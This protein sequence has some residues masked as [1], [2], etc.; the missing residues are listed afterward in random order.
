MI[1]PILQF[2]LAKGT[3]DAAIKK[4][5]LLSQVHNIQEI[6]KI[7]SE[8]KRL[9]LE[10]KLSLTTAEA[11]SNILPQAIE[12]YNAL[13]S[14]NIDLIWSGHSQYPERLKNVLGDDAPP[15]LFVKGNKNLLKNVGVGFCGARSSSA[16]GLSI[17]AKCSEMLV[18][19]GF[20]VVSGYA[21]GVDI[22]A[23]SAALKS[24]GMTT[25]VLAEGILRF[26]EKEEVKGL[27]NDNNHIIVSQFPPNLTWIAR[28]A[29][30]RNHL[31]IAL[32]DAMILIEA[33]ASGGTFAAGEATLK[34]NQP[35]FVVDYASPPESASGNELLIKRGGLLLKQTR[36]FE[37]NL[38]KVI[39]KAKEQ[40][41]RNSTS[42][43]NEDLLF[44]F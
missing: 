29:M 22:A 35:L 25:I 2:I 41:I 7:C 14:Q 37:P 12:L 11:I 19:H 28:N 13:H 24:N 26:C 16:Q 43:P 6:R 18:N 38:T 23:H 17:A 4:L 33:G 20:N 3:G 15:Y 5:L 40:F 39:Q 42:L 1:I 27:L 44:D 9:M 8:K 30:R 36:E 32:S 34:H 21:K 10:L 31:I